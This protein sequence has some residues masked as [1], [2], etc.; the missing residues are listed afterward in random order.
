[1]VRGIA[2]GCIAP[3]KEATTTERAGGTFY[4]MPPGQQQRPSQIDPSRL[5]AVF[6]GHRIG[7]SLPEM[8]TTLRHAPQ[9][10]GAINEAWRRWREERPHDQRLVG[11]DAM[12][13]NHLPSDELVPVCR[14]LRNTLVREQMRVA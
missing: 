13:M 10:R 6:N 8:R 3:S 2:C 11:L 1:L 4:V 12:T 5:D 7:R 9:H 14:E